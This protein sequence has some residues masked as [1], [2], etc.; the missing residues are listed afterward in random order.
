MLLPNTNTN[1]CSVKYYTFLSR[2]KHKES[3]TWGVK[4]RFYVTHFFVFVFWNVNICLAFFYC[5]PIRNWLC[6]SVQFNVVLDK[7]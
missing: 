6:S 7:E 3:I 2:G 4:L 5:T 1:I